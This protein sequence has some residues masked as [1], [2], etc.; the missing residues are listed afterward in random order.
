M[1]DLHNPKSMEK[2]SSA[3]TL[4]DMEIFIFPELMYALA[5]ANIMSPLI[6]EWKDDSWFSKL[7]TMSDYRKIHRIKQYI[8]N[9][10]DF[11][12]DLDTWGLTD[13]PSEMNRFQDFVDEATLSQSNALFG[14]EGDKYY[15]DIDIRRHF[16]LDKY[17]SDVIPYWKTETVDAMVSFQLREGYRKGAGECV[18]LSTLYY[19]ALVIL[20]GIPTE[21]IYMIA[22]PL[23]SQNFVDLGDGLLTNN[24]R[25]VTHNMWFNGTELSNKAKRALVNERVTFVSSSTGYVHRIYDEATM[26]AEQYRHFQ[27]RLLDFLSTEISYEILVNFLREHNHLQRCFQLEHSRFGHT[28]YIPIEKI[29]QYEHSSNFRAGTNTEE[30]LLDD[31]DEDVFYPHPM[32]NRLSLNTLK[33]IFDSHSFTL[34]TLERN[35]ETLTDL[36]G[37]YCERAKEIVTELLVFCRTVPLLPD[38]DKTV[39][40]PQKHDLTLRGLRSRTE[41]QEALSSL[42]EQDELVGLAFMAYRDIRGDYWYPFLKASLER[43]PVCLAATRDLAPRTIYEQLLKLP[44]QSIYSEDRLAQP[45]EVHNFGTGDGLEKALYLLTVLNRNEP[46]TIW[47]LSRNGSK[48]T[49]RYGDTVYVFLTAKNCLIPENLYEK[50]MELAIG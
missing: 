45:D 39:V 1:L 14:Y 19:A 30:K 10:F 25:L 41:I 3:V 31:I 16:G 38:I 37:S 29:F 40:R 13:K 7:D 22:T 23:H 21:D 11:N 24:R 36:L 8:M 47:T 50:A 46:R 17:T 26:P 44:N 32:E 33:E 35:P 48:V 43:N 5:L 4:S 27:N 34:D 6:W 49:L 28:L 42:R 18:S 9:H 12:L 15:F 2:Y 20:G